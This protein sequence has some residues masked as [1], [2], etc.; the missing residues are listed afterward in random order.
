MISWSHKCCRQSFVE[1]G[2]LVLEKKIFEG[3]L[4]YMGVATIFGHVTSIMLINF[5]F[6]V[7]KS[8]NYKIWWKIAQWFLR[9]ASFNFHMYMTLDQGQEMTL[10]FNTHIPSLTQLAVFSSQA[11]I[12]SEKSTVFTLGI[13]KT[14]L[15][16]LTLS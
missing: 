12:I 15:Q 6:L 5:H 2:L 10:T 14:K 8:L 13:E 7:P 3:V 1:I 16:K 11:A 4:P 9:K